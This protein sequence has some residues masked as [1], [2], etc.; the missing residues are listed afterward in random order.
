MR[1]TKVRAVKH[2]RRNCLLIRGANAWNSLPERVVESKSVPIF[3][4]R[5][6]KLF[7]SKMFQT[8]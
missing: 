8:D 2:G 1:L 6:D 4:N 3:K 7:K 5:L